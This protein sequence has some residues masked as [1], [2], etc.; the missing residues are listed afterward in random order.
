MAHDVF[1]SYSTKDKIIADAVCAKLEEHRIRVW[2]APRDVPAGSNFAQSIIRAIN[3][4]KVFVLIWSANSNTSNHILNEINQAFDQGITIIPFRIQDI[5]PTDEMRYYF[6]R[7]HWLDAITPPLENHIAVLRD[8]ILINLGREPQPAKPPVDSQESSVEGIQKPITEKEPTIERA[9]AVKPPLSTPRRK[10]SQKIETKIRPTSTI[11]ANLSRFIPFAAGGLVV[12]TLVVLL[13]LGVF[14]KSPS[15]GI[16]QTSPETTSPISPTSITKPTEMSTPIPAWMDEADAV[17]KPILVTIKKFQPDFEDDFSQVDTDW[18]YNPGDGAYDC[19]VSDETKMDV[20]GGSLKSSL[21]SDCPAAAIAPPVSQYDNYVLQLDV[22]FSGAP[23]GI[24]LRNWG[25]SADDE[26]VQ[27]HYSLSSPEGNWGLSR[28]GNLIEGMD[29]NIGLDFSKPVTITI[30]NQSPIYIVY[31]DSSL[32]TFYN[33]QEE[34]GRFGLDFVFGI[35]DVTRTETLTL[36]LDNAKIWDL[37]RI[38]EVNDMAESIL[39]MIHKFP[40]D[41][42]DDFSQVDPN[43]YSPPGDTPPE[44]I[45]PGEASMSITD[46]TMKYSITDCQV[47]MLQH[48]DMQY[49]N[50]VLQ[51]DVDFQEAPLGI[52]F[53]IWGPSVQLDYYLQSPEGKWGFAVIKKGVFIEKIGGNA[54]LDFSKPVTIT[55]INQSPAFIV[56][57]DSSLLTFYNTQESYAGSFGLDFTVNSWDVTPAETLMLELDNVKIWDLDKI[58]E[59]NA[60]AESTLAMIN[61]FPPSFA[62]DFSQ[63]DPD[64]SYNLDDCPGIG[65]AP[66]SVVDDGIHFTI[67]PDCPLIALTHPGFQNQSSDY[68]MQMDINFQQ[69]N[70]GFEFDAGSPNGFVVDFILWDEAWA[71][72]KPIPTTDEMQTVGNEPVQSNAPDPVRLS[73]LK[74][75]T[76]FL[77]YLNSELLTVYDIQA[78]VAYDHEIGFAVNN[79]SDAPFDPETIMLDEI[80]VWDL[81]EIG[82][83]IA[84]SETTLAAVQDLPSDFMDDFSQVDANWHS[85][86]GNN[87]PECINTGEATMSI[88]DGSMKYSILNCQVGNLQYA[89]MAYANY[90]LQL[91]I[92]FQGDPLGLEFRNWGPSALLDYHIHH[93]G[94]WGFSVWRGEDKIE[95]MDGN[96]GLDFSKPVTITIINKSPTFIIYLDSSLLTLYRTQEAYAGPFVLDFTVNSWDVT[97]IETLTL[98]LDNVKIWDLDKIEY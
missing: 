3:A 62:D 42:T 52:E 87:P 53:R 82:E 25:R 79:W 4:C 76:D 57:L 19:R 64:W 1:I 90:V 37:D 29:G 34:Y 86:P 72:F 83:S 9:E 48:T 55:I 5:Q 54:N 98:E 56:Y 27:L 73:I 77:F 74:K 39:T 95:G 7:T 35:G 93:D 2:I 28:N 23:L 16:A 58:D 11:P 70:I 30:I 33:S 12:V 38:E 45:N 89:D 65:S 20:T 63:V 67:S 69:T 36:E 71:T 46:G 80:K 31:V 14:K 92:N 22:N 68:V 81:E 13:L 43:W 40:P 78:E 75:G 17:A 91:D 51:L 32:I 6:G 24:E 44:C 84:F 47:G 21:G 49:D 60:M 66:M 26:D 50:Y 94:S 41:F 96:A 85:P 61:N 88:T 8:T 18:S 59:V 15:A 10:M 97:P